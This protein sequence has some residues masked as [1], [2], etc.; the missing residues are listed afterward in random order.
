M[1]KCS[2]IMI[3]LLYFIM[4][5]LASPISLTYEKRDSSTG[6]SPAIWA[7][8]V[9]V[10]LLIFGTTAFIIWRRRKQARPSRPT[11]TT[12][13][14]EL[15]AAQ[16]TGQPENTPA[17]TARPRRAR[18]GR[19]P[20]Q[21]SVTSL[22]E[23]MKTPGDN[24]V[25]IFRGP[26]DMEDAPIR[27]PT[28]V[29]IEPNSTIAHSR[30]NSELSVYSQ[31]PETPQD[32]PLMSNN[33]HTHSSNHSTDMTPPGHLFNGDRNS[34]DT[35]RSSG[36]E[37]N[38]LMRVQTS[39]TPDPRGEAPPYFEVV[40]LQDIPASPQNTTAPQGNVQEPTTTPPASP[41]ANRRSGFRSIFQFGSMRLA[42]PQNS[43]TTAAIHTRE[44][45]VP[46]VI[47]SDASHAQSQSSHRPSMS[48]GSLLSLTPF[49]SMSRQRSITSMRGSALNSP[50]M[51]SLN[52]ISAPLTHTV[53]RT[54]FT[55]P[56]SGP[57][58][59]QV[60]LI[61]SREAFSKFGVPYGAD[62]VAFAASTSRQELEPPPDFEAS[63]SAL[64]LTT[65]GNQPHHSP[66]PSPHATPPSPSHIPL[67]DS[68]L[69]VHTTLALDP[70][71]EED[72]ETTAPATLAPPSSFR[73]DEFR[74]ESRASSISYATAAETIGPYSE[75]DEPPSPSTPKSRRMVLEPT[76]ATITPATRRG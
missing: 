5:A 68:P 24:E 67:P 73:F 55:Y 41:P 18:R 62:A 63:T 75:T 48:G 70:E 66:T 8:I 57:T 49:R 60:K 71:E 28:T 72:L 61:S 64:N 15:T 22:P 6:A 9:A 27:S 40:D 32:M 42:A 65:A 10:A 37:V 25:V 16:L 54:E 12:S 50:S 14:R 4:P 13:T 30:A 38:S 53:T 19:R 51:I 59:E 58:P 29:V 1:H 52:S 20:S 3:P 31:I 56:K 43:G 34:V 21:I 11:A 23:Y 44:G 45:S 69:S 26:A 39:S 74:P 35:S 33:D 7:S 17:Q 47:A 36:D 2:C 76:D 46:S